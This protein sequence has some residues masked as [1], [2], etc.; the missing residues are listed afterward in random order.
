M[1]SAYAQALAGQHRFLE[2]VE[3]KAALQRL[4]KTYD[5]ANEELARKLAALVKAGKGETF[6]AHQARQMLVQIK[7]GQVKLA[8]A[9]AGK[10]GAETK[11]VQSSAVKKLIQ[12]IEQLEKKYTGAAFEMPMSEVAHFT[13]ATGKREQ[14]LLKMHKSSM[15]NYGIKNVDRM[16]RAMATALASGVTNDEAIAKIMDAADVSWSQ[17]ERIVRTEL[18]WAFNATQADGIEAAAAELPDMMMRW[19]EHCT[20][21]GVPLDDRVAVDSIAMHGQLTAPGGLFVM[22][23]TAP[24]PDAKGVTKV[25]DRLVGMSWE[26]PPNRPNDRSVVQPWRPHWGI[27]G[28]MWHDG[29]RVPL[30][31]KKG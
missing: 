21:A 1:A 18:S 13:G 10:L 14:S 22:P 9:M 15:A 25:P 24:H 26:F 27:P 2:Q 11:G 16:E 23:P 30:K 28:W 29:R 17:G 20:D 4:K 19:S 31:T 7:A 3:T 6:T 8:Q 5:A 12:E